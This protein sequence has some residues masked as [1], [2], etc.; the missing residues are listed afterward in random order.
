MWIAQSL[1]KSFGVNTRHP[2]E[3][4]G[5][6][7]K[8]SLVDLQQKTHWFCFRITATHVF[9]WYDDRLLIQWFD[10]WCFFETWWKIDDFVWEYGEYRLH[11][12]SSAYLVIIFTPIT[13]WYD[14]EMLIY[15]MVQTF[16][17]MIN[18]QKIRSIMI[19]LYNFPK[20][21]DHLIQQITIRKTSMISYSPSPL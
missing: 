1:I 13:W 14:A 12:K 11:L 15:N 6:L 3:R 16:L 4:L 17:M 21:W 19:I 20:T 18:P 2:D 9:C 7:F 8:K 10:F 5:L